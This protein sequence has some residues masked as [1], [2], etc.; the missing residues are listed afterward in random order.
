MGVRG[1]GD[2]RATERAEELPVFEDERL[3]LRVTVGKVGEGERDLDHDVRVARLER[4]EEAR[5]DQRVEHRVEIVL[6]VGKV[7]QEVQHLLAHA[8]VHVIEA[9]VERGSA[10]APL[11]SGAHL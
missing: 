9:L 10:D 5:G 3:A 1:G 7:A 2:E 6:A 4:P 8:R 11:V